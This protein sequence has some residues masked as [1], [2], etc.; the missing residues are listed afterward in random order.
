MSKNKIN[1]RRVRILNLS[2]FDCLTEIEHAMY[3]A[4][5]KCNKPDDK[6]VLKTT[7]DDMIIAYTGIREI[8]KNSIFKSKDGVL[9]DEYRED[10]Q[11]ALFE[12][13]L[14]RMANDMDTIFP[15]IKEIVYLDIHHLDILK[16]I[17]HNGVMINNKK[18]IV[19]SS[20]TNQQKKKMVT[21]LEEE[22]Y[23]KNVGKIMCGLSIN[24]INEGNDRV[25]GCNRGKYL[26]YTSLPMSSSI[27]LSRIDEK[28]PEKYSIDI[29]KCIVVKD[30]ETVVSGMVNYLDVNTLKT[31][32]KMMNIPILHM[33]GSGIFL[34]GVLPSSGQI[35]G[36]WFKGALF[37]FDFRKFIEVNK[38]KG[39]S[40]IVPDIYGKPHDIIEEDIQC[41]M[42]GSQLKMWKYYKDWDEYKKAFNENGC[43]IYINNLAHE[44][45]ENATVR[46]SYQFLQTILREN[47]T[48]DAM[49][50]LCAKSLNYINGA[51]N[52]KEI[53]YQMMGIDDK[54]ELEP[55][56]AALKIYP[57]MLYDNYAKKKI[58]DT[59]RSEQHRAMSAKLIVDGFYSYICPDLYAFC[60]WLF[61]NIAEPVGLIPKN[62][63]YN[64]YYNNKNDIDIVD[65]LRSPHLSDTE[66]GVRNLIKSDECKYWFSGTD[67]VVST[68]DLLSKNLMND[69][70]GDEMLIT[71]SKEL[72]D[73]VDLEKVPLYYEMGS[74]ENQQITPDVLYQGLESSFKNSIIGDIS[75]CITKLWNTVESSD[76]DFIRVLTAYNNYMI[77]YPK[78]QFELPLQDYKSRYEDLTDNNI[79]KTPYF[80]IYAKDKSKTSCEPLNVS[81]VNRICD[82]IYK[83]TRNKRYVLFNGAGCFNAVYLMDNGIN[84]KRASEEYKELR[85][86]IKNLKEQA[87]AIEGKLKGVKRKL[88]ENENFNEKH[89]KYDLFYHTCQEKILKIFNEDR[90]VATTYLVDIEYFQ[91]ENMT[92]SKNIL[93]NC[94]GDIIVENIKKN[95]ISKE[96]IKVKR[97]AYQTKKKEDKETFDIIQKEITEALTDKSIII[98]QDELHWVE[99]Q[100]HRKNCS[101]D[102]LLLFVLLYMH[103]KYAKNGVFK[104][105]LNS[106]TKGITPATINTWIGSDVCK[107]GLVRLQNKE[108]L[109]LEIITGKYYEVRL[110]VPEDNSSNEVFKINKGNPLIPFFEHTGERKIKKC[111]I[112]SNEYIA[113]G[114][115]KTCSKSCSKILESETKEK[116]NEKA[117]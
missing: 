20:S 102:R 42:T 85:V 17:L 110:N 27:E 43:A 73:L 83:K 92:N 58:E 52:N 28:N 62:Y 68:H 46:L 101:L 29:N 49:I 25:E 114:N 56:Q 10:K 76:I 104:I 47:F 65:C 6:K 99:S 19:Y 117:S 93:W 44:P 81:N 95:L 96:P 72:I 5:K 40:P 55:F 50:K 12:S 115:A 105:F 8:S 79:V 34:P 35:R 91:N 51:K 24:K 66:H 53:M 74:S 21:L 80:F 2:T 67:T 22:F 13:E 94:F 54:K 108:L 41:I 1:A 45:E 60:E 82:Y 57:D 30:F 100:E 71:S 90:I 39:A 38:E 59:V 109:K 86:L 3:N 15:L 97:N 36:G 69:W 4:Y 106:K 113:E 63:V 84:V 48:D 88:K 61:C 112:C 23:N 111:E 14:V 98:S 64:S 89:L 26:A 16:Q 107:K 87:Q 33:D 103:K 77:D 37:P 70:D 18:Y 7:L 11:I 75:N 31:E 9:T 32:P 78:T 116:L